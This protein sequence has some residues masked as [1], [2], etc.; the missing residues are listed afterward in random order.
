M[1][2]LNRKRKLTAADVRQIWQL[3]NEGVEQCVIAE[4]FGVHQTTISRI[5]LGESWTHLFAGR[6]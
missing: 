1:S 6:A 5:K 2:T 3:L 4:Q